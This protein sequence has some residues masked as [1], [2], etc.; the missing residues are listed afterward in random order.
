MK[1]N[2]ILWEEKNLTEPMMNYGNKNESEI[3]DITSDT[4]K[5]L[6]RNLCCDILTK[7]CPKCNQIQIYKNK[8]QLNKALRNN[9][10]CKS[11]AGIQTKFY[12]YSNLWKTHLT[13]R[14]K[15]WS[16]N[17]PR[18][19]LKQIYK[20]KRNLTKAYMKTQVCRKCQL[21]IRKSTSINNPNYNP[22]A[23]KYFDKLNDKMG[24]SLCHAM[25]GGEIKYDKYWLDAYDKEK[26]IIVEY[27]E[28]HHFR[29][30][31]LLQKDIDRMNDIINKL[32]C[33]FYRYD[34]CNGRLVEYTNIR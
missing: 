13:D 24:W 12:L 15:I 27:D 28:K 30:G 16:K 3:N 6:M 20:T 18:C 5:N 8:R 7:N 4:E 11:C 29:Y 1:E 26:N 14:D 9:T 21:I 32:H 22:N 23:C 34:E 17:C 25:N 31:K 2:T 33:K 10:I 19:N